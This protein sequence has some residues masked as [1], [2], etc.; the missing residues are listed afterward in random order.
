M[1][2]LPLLLKKPRGFS[3]NFSPTAE[4][5]VAPLSQC[6]AVLFVLVLLTSCG[7][8]K[9][10]PKP[11]I[12]PRNETKAILFKCDNYINQGMGLPVDVIY[13][14]AEDNLKEVTKIGPDAWFD[15]EERKNWPFKQTLMLKG[16]EEIMLNLSRPP[17][18]KFIVIFASFIAWRI[19]K[20]SR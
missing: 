2:K 9:S 16:G 10:P 6:G 5:M 14:T 3:P 13:V 12:P 18:T 19:K 8:F 15:S 20:R 11:Y 1:K 17:E 7:I 4:R